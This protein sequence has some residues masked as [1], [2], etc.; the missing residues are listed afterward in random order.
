MESEHYITAF[1]GLMGTLIGAGVS[2]FA[3]VY[4][5]SKEA[6]LRVQEKKLGY[7]FNISFDLF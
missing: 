3:N 7:F 6:K 2:F 4:Q 5:S 1:V